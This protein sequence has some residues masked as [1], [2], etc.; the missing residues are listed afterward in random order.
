MLQSQKFEGGINLGKTTDLKDIRNTNDA[1]ATSYGKYPNN[2]KD[3]PTISIP[4]IN[5]DAGASPFL[6]IDRKVG[7]FTLGGIYDYATILCHNGF[8]NDQ[9]IRQRNTIKN[10]TT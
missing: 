1:E 10:V 5:Y 4:I 3:N 2:V 7:K 8:I 6:E 9:V